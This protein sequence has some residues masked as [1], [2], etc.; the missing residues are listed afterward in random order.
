M[1]IENDKEKLMKKGSKEK[2]ENE[3]EGEERWWIGVGELKRKK[4]KKV[5]KKDGYEENEEGKESGKVEE[6][7]KK[8]MK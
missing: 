2:R 6:E 5:D 4:C 1:R 3:K 8:E 7:G